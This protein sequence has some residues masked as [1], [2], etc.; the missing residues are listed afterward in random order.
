MESQPQNPEFRINPE[1]FR[2]MLLQAKFFQEY[3]QKQYGSRFYVKTVCKG[4]SA[5]D[6]SRLKGTLSISNVH[7]F[8][9]HNLSINCLLS[10]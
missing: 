2:P 1:N 10:G 8:F 3:P 5:D 4:I 7:I 9:G 6:T